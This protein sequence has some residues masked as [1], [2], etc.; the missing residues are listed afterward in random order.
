MKKLVL[1]LI[2]ICVLNANALQY[3]F[4][5]TDAEAKLTNDFY[6]NPTEENFNKMSSTHKAFVLEENMACFDVLKCDYYENKAKFERLNA[7]FKTQLPRLSIEEREMYYSLV[8]QKA[9]D[10]AAEAGTEKIEFAGKTYTSSAELIDALWVLATNNSPQKIHALVC[11]QMMLPAYHKT[12]GS[13]AL[14]EFARD[15]VMERL[16][17]LKE[18]L[19][20]FNGRINENCLVK[21]IN[22]NQLAFS[23]ADIFYKYEQD[24]KA[25]AVVLKTN[26]P[27]PTI[28]TIRSFTR[29]SYCQRERVQEIARSFVDYQNKTSGLSG[30][31]VLEGDRTCQLTLLLEKKNKEWF[32]VDF[33]NYENDPRKERKP[34]R[35]SAQLVEIIM[36]RQLSLPK[37]VVGGTTNLPTTAKPASAPAARVLPAAR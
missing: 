36:A 5:P 33:L 31:Y 10:N 35:D 16:A 32:V 26:K 11:D 25:N 22:D 29:A 4:R 2:I 3:Y 12:A 24:A 34:F 8:L 21:D 7:F 1:I 27:K 30:Y 15:I 19:R 23:M 9:I 13:P 37:P 28:Q 14:H 20:Q 17:Y 18:K 6:R